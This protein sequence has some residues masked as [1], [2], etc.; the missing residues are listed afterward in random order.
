MNFQQW[1]NLY[2][3][4]MDDTPGLSQFGEESWNACK[5]EVLKILS[6]NANSHNPAH[7][8]TLMKSYKEIKENL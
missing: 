8:W 3:E 6:K 7:D 5:K 2:T 1:L 4:R